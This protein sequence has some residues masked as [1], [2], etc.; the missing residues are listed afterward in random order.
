MKLFLSSELGHSPKRSAKLLGREQM[1]DFHHNQT[2]PLSEGMWV[3]SWDLTVLV[4]HPV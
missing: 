1:S 3:V 2:T 4:S